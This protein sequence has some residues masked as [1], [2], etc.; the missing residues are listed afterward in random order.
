MPERSRTAEAW[1]EGDWTTAVR[2][3]FFGAVLDQS[4][5]LIERWPGIPHEWKVWLAHD[6][7]SAA[8][9]CTYIFAQSPG[10]T[11]PDG[12]W[13]A[14]D[15]LVV[16]VDELATNEPGLT[17]KGMGYTVPVLAEE[18]QGHV[19]HVERRRSTPV[20]EGAAD[21]RRG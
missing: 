17:D 6:W 11:G 12:R 1:L 21:G 16:V 18:D 8:P 20:P 13:Y 4:R 10:A 3:A 2:G 14:R 7:G 9:S 5:N 15:S 19:R